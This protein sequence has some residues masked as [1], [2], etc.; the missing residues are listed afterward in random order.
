MNLIS[1]I[2]SAELRFKRVLE[3]FFISHYHEKV[4]P[5]HGIDHH[6]RVWNYSKE[7]LSLLTDNNSVN[8]S[9]LPEKLIITS[10]LH[11]IGMSVNP[12][13]EHGRYSRE[14]CKEFMIQQHISEND[15]PGV[16]DAIENHDRKNYI[17]PKGEGRLLEILSV[18]D[19][20]DAFGFIG[21]YRYTEIYLIRGIRIE[22]IG[23]LILKNAEKRFENFT[24]TPGLIDKFIKNQKERYDI[25][26]QFFNGFNNQLP[27]YR[28]GGKPS[29][30]CGSIELIPDMGSK[31]SLLSDIEKLKL[32]YS[33]EPVIYTFFD[34]LSRELLTLPNC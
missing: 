17:D 26:I 18:A 19:D 9:Q 33:E 3:D 14:L 22:E 13:F 25:L 6:R 31:I 21:I 24:R 1:Q 2:G 20:L 30:Y 29:G 15:F 28:F 16:L 11:D 7:L 27:F 5:S 32:K 8:F 23:N 34:G 10:Y 12:D 4:L